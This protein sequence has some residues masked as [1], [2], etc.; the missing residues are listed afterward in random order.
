MTEP[1]EAPADAPQRAAAG[2]ERSALARRSAF[3]FVG[4]VIATGLQFAMLLV[5]ARALGQGDAG[6]FFQGFSALRLLTVVAAIGLDVTL[7]RYVAVH[8]ARGEH[9]EARAAVRVATLIAAA[10]SLVTTVAVFALAPPLAAAF[11]SPDLAYVMRVMVL[12][13]PLVTLQAVLIGATRGTGSMRAYV[14]V[15]QVLDGAVRLA[16]VA[17]GVWLGYGLHG[18]VWGYT[19]ASVVLTAAAAISATGLLRGDSRARSGQLAE[20][21]RFTSLQWGAIMAGVGL[22]WADTLLLGLWRSD[23]D[24]AVYSFATRTVVAG[25]V[26][27]LPIGV[28]FQPMIARLYAARDHA[29]LAAMYSFATKWSTLAACPP[30]LFL[31]LFATPVMVLLYDRSY[32]DGAWP[33]ALLALGQMANAATGPCGHLVTMT[34]RSDLVLKNSVAALIL[35]IV[36]SVALIPPFGLIGAAAGWA[37]TIVA[38]NLYRLVQAWQILHV[39]PFSGWPA[40]AG[41]ALALGTAS[42]AGARLLTDGLA[43]APAIAV[44]V[45]FGGLV[46]AAALHLLDLLSGVDR[47]LGALPLGRARARAAAR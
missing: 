34:G 11:D 45:V 17:I 36:L 37:I 2:G 16:G 14:V 31:A 18:A 19:I 39:Q 47:L 13:V 4:L 7:V 21:M 32:A 46:Y 20:L 10:A 9:D 35:R 42:T 1:L 25:M 27:I 23:E 30:L 24:V 43:P 22:L 8:R 40:R 38:W 12:S 29:R 44:G 15:D 3:N 33:L 6:V 41:A 26:F 28:A 5:L